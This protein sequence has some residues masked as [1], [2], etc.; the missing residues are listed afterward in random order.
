MENYAEPLGAI[1]NCQHF[2]GNSKSTRVGPGVQSVYQFLN[3]LL[4]IFSTFPFLFVAANKGQSSI[5][6]PPCAM[7]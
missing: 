7:L 4:L 3:I 2:L 6:K 1:Q 5:I